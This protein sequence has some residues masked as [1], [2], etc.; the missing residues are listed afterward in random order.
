MEGCPASFSLKDYVFDEIL[1]FV[2]RV[3]RN[4]RTN[5]NF[6][7]SCIFEKLKSNAKLIMKVT[8]S[9]EGQDS[10]F[11]VV[12]CKANFLFDGVNSVSD[13]PQYFYTN[14]IA[15]LYP[16]IRAMVSLVTVQSNIG[17]PVV[18]PLLNLTPLGEE[19]KKLT[20]EE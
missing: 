19:L 14:S 18:L 2:N 4:K 20:K 13:I 12:S 5:I 9:S 15:I 3:D 8:I 6:E 7:P 10:P 17:R 1:F 11:C 16:Y